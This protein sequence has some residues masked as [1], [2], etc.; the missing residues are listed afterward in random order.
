MQS[1]FTSNDWESQL[2]S[3][4]LDLNHYFYVDGWS[5]CVERFSPNKY[6]A[7]DDIE[8]LCSYL[9]VRIYFPQ[10]QQVQQIWKTIFLFLTSWFPKLPKY[11]SDLERSKRLIP[12]M[13][14]FLEKL[15]DQ[16]KLDHRDDVIDSCPIEITSKHRCKQSKTANEIANEI[17]THSFCAS[18]RLNVQN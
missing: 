10:I 14:K 16:V 5:S 4:Y 15:S 2:I 11:N 8:V 18:K 3:L 1:L 12:V 7:F 6:P 17:A 9:F 13:I